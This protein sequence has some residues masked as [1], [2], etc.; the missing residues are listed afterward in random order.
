MLIGQ[1]LNLHEAIANKEKLLIEEN[2]SL[3]AELRSRY[4]HHNIIGQCKIMQELFVI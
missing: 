2:I 3:K 4:S 1:F